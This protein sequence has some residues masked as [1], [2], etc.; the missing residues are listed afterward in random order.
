MRRKKSH[1]YKKVINTKEFL[2]K[3]VEVLDTY[4]GYR[5][6]LFC[7]DA[8]GHGQPIID[9]YH[10]KIIFYVKDEVVN[11]IDGW[12]GEDPW[13]YGEIKGIVEFAERY[14][15]KELGSKYMNYYHMEE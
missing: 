2:E 9:G 8:D 15:P 7:Y 3:T 10:W 5:F 11:E 6:K 1:I 13:R 12:P 14:I 4:N